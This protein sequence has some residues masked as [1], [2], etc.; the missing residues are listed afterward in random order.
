MKIAVIEDEVPAR[1]HLL[2]LII[3][4]RPNSSVLFTAGSVKESL[5]Q[6]EK[7]VTPDLIFMDIQLNDGLSLEIF[8]K[9]QIPSPIVFTTAFDQ[10]TLDAF[11][12]NGIEYLLKPI[13]LADVNRAFEKFD[14]L[15]GHFQGKIESLI[16][17]FQENTGYRKRFTA[18]KGL[19]FKS[20]PIDDIAYFYSEHKVSFLITKSGEKL[21]IDDSLA[22]LE[23]MVN[24]NTFYRINRKYLASIESI[25]Q[26]KSFEKGKLLVQFI[27]SSEEEVIV[28][29]EKASDFKNWFSK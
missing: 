20:T 11:Q 3:K 21:I 7:H 15:K 18:K 26:F 14:G 2:N 1:E 8:Q 16:E 12:Q 4:V 27:P 25:D 23:G 29:Q 24:P 13:K 17:A 5:Q 22:D 10:Y 19:A 28:S 6:F 9:T